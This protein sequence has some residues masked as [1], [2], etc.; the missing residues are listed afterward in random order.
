MS[1]RGSIA[2]RQRVTNRTGRTDIGFSKAV[3]GVMVQLDWTNASVKRVEA[4][5]DFQIAARLVACVRGEYTDLGE[6]HVGISA[7]MVFYFVQ[8]DR[9]N[10]WYYI[11][12]SFNGKR[13][14]SCPAHYNTKA[15][16]CKH[17]DKVEE[18][19]VERDRQELARAGEGAHVELVEVEIGAYIYLQYRVVSPTYIGLLQYVLG[20]D[21]RPIHYAAESVSL[22][23]VA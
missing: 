13:F 6:T 11:V 22:E 2:T 7:G 17:L 8:A 14:C 21:R 16:S 15:K 18:F 10:G 5:K 12:F 1:S 23:L 19:C 3:E 20:D 4:R 9:G